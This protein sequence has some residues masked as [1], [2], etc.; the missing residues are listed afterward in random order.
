[1]PP[2]TLIVVQDRIRA[3]SAERGRVLESLEAALRVGRGRV[4]IHVVDDSDP[5]KSLDCWRYSSELHGAHCDLSYREP[6]PSLFSFNSPVGAC[7]KCRGFGRT[8]GID[9]GLV[10]PDES[11]SLRGGAIRPWQTQ[12]YKE[13]QDDLIKFGKKRNIPLDRPWRELSETHKAWVIEGEGPWSKDVWYGAK[14]FFDWLETKSYKMHVRV[15]LSR[16]RAYTPCLT[17]N[18]ARLK[19]EAL[20][21]RLGNRELANDV[22]PAGQRFRPA[23]VKWSDATFPSLPGLTIHDIMLLPLE[24]A[25]AFFQ[26]L[27]LP[28]PLDEATDL[29]LGEIRT[30]FNYLNDVGL[31]YLTLD[32]QSRTLSGGEVQR[33]NL[34]TALGTSLVNTLFVL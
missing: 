8:I 2:K 19:T 33:I 13:C 16:Y 32:R 9:Y 17:C 7:E 26:K 20:L 23:G 25:C 1:L 18:G 12:S 10:I 14:R 21:W 28:K 22:L 15:L 6:I 34:T 3:S 30:R 11:K 5:P 27:E 29:L 24:R 4:H 31:G